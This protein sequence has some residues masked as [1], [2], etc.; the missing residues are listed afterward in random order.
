MQHY[1]IEVTNGDSMYILENISG[2]SWFVLFLMHLPSALEMGGS[3]KLVS[4]VVR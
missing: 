4:H 2:T 1:F 3:F